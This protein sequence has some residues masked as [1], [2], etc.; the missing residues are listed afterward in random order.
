MRVVVVGAGAIGLST[1]YFLASQGAEVT[2]LD[3]RGIGSGASRTNAGW[4]VPA[5]SGPVPAPGMFWKSARWML[6]RQSP[7][8]I[9]LSLDPAFVGF[10]LQMLRHCNARDYEHGLRATVELNQ[11]TFELFDLLTE[12]GVQ[13]EQHRAGVTSLFLSESALDEHA[14]ESRELEELGV[15]AVEVLTSAEVRRESPAVSPRIVGGIKFAHQRFLDPDSFVEGL[16]AA[17]GRLGVEFRL[18]ERAT[19]LVRV[20]NRAAA[21]RA[22]QTYAADAFVL[23]TGAWSSRFGPTLGVRVPIQPGRGYGFDLPR[24]PKVQGALYLTEGKVAVTPLATKLRLAE[25]W[26]SPP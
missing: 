15:S 13:F 8:K 18:G 1:A 5:M 16:H 26:S 25:R 23:A 17:C 7:L 24:S 14:N 6:Q 22:T 9:K 20:G 4:I 19:E 10:M 3:A 2:V 11:R 12:S 21:V